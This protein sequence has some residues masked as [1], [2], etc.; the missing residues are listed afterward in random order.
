MVCDGVLCD[1]IGTCARYIE[2]DGI[3]DYCLAIHYILCY[4]RVDFSL[5]P[6]EIVKRHRYLDTLVD[7]GVS[8]HDSNEGDILVG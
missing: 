5:M 3:E 2:D 4:F 6:Y 7:S 8:R 1:E